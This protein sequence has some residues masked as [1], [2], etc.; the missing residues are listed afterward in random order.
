MLPNGVTYELLTTENQI[1]RA[2]YTQVRKV[3]VAPRYLKI[4]NENNTELLD[5]YKD[6]T[7]IAKQNPPLINNYN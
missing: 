6:N 3:R 1:I 7:N 5:I 2:H 4:I